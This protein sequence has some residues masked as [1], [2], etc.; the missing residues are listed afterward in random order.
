MLNAVTVALLLIKTSRLLG[1]TQAW[2]LCE[3]LAQS[4][5]AS[6][7]CVFVQLPHFASQCLAQLL[8]AARG[9]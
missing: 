3:V 6:C 4:H 2:P 8:R 9:S 1:S 5:G 7:E